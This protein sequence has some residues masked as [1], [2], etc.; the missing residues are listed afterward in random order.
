M[1]EQFYVRAVNRE[2][3]AETLEGPIGTERAAIERAERM[4]EEYFG[5]DDAT[6]FENVGAWRYQ[7]GRVFDGGGRSEPLVT[8]TIEEQV[9]EV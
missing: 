3:G 6:W 1:A 4:A 2:T 7:V 8:I 5:G 9:D